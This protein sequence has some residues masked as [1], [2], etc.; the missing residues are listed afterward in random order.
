MPEADGKNRSMVDTKNSCKT[1]ILRPIYD[2][3]LGDL[4]DPD[5]LFSRTGFKPAAVREEGDTPTLTTQF[6]NDALPGKLDETSKDAPSW[7]SKFSSC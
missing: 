1:R 3:G 7:L 5:D 4:G 6:L 2:E